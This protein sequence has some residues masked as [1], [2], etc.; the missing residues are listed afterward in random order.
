MKFAS[1]AVL[2]ASA[3]ALVD[4]AGPTGSVHGGSGVDTA[5]GVGPNGEDASPQHIAGVTDGT[6]SFN[7]YT[8]RTV[9]H[10]QPAKFYRA[11]HQEISPAQCERLCSVSNKC[12][13]YFHQ[14]LLNGIGNCYFSN[15]NLLYSGQPYWVYNTQVKAS[16]A[17]NMVVDSITSVKLMDVKNSAVSQA[18]TRDMLFV[19]PVRPQLACRR[20]TCEYK[21]G[22]VHVYHDSKEI[23]TM[24]YSGIHT[25]S[26]LSADHNCQF[27]HQQQSCGCT[28]AETGSG[29][30]GR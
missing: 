8:F 15:G 16:A 19:D 29:L 13:S 25:M 18:K 28:C 20:V 11:T 17:G 23:E 5:A 4:Q 1:A 7:K 6:A 14:D 2:L 30:L 26:H 21:Q 12:T 27:N 3:A 10:A 9:T 24:A 22:R